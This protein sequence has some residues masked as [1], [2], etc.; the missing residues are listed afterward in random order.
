M[1]GWPNGHKDI[2]FSHGRQ[3]AIL[4]F[5]LANDK[6]LDVT[7]GSTRPLAGV[8]ICL[9]STRAGGAGLNLVGA[10]RLVLFDSD[11]N[12]AVDLQAMARVWRDGQRK[13]CLVYRLLTTGLHLLPKLLP[14]PPPL[15]SLLF[16]H[17]NGKSWQNDACFAASFVATSLQQLPNAL[18]LPPVSCG[19]LEA[20]GNLSQPHFCTFRLIPLNLTSQ[21]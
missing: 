12:P 8:Q 21:A 2:G 20:A 13:P 10:N 4:T 6:W 19:K 14:P 11:W 16:V 7:F 5:L 1:L 9:L 17:L 3:D 18:C 15:L